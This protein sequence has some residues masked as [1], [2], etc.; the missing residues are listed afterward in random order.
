MKKP[1]IAVDVD[2]VLAGINR[3]MMEFVNKEFGTNL[4][5]DDYTA[6]GEYHQYWEKIWGVSNEE[7]ERR[8]QAFVEAESHGNLPLIDGATQAIDH[9]KKRFEL[10]IITA[11]DHKHKDETHQWLAQHFPQTFKDVLFLPLN[12]EDGK[13]VHKAVVAKEIGASYLIDDN[14][15]HCTV[16]H[17]AGITALLFGDYGWNKHHQIPKGV[18]RVKDWQAVKEHFD[19][20]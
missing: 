14:V 2:D 15:D 18:I 7:A 6:P 5:W 10:V 13:K 17:Q 20:R 12:E 9:L 3:A 8:Y 4:T 1:I 11:R 19:A 16:A